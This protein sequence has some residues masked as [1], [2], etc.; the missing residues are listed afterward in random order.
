MTNYEGGRGRRVKVNDISDLIFVA[1]KENVVSEEARFSL[2][3]YWIIIG[4]INFGG[5]ERSL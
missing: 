3:D 2:N 4:V 1:T 5:K